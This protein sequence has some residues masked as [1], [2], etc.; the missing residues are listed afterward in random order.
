M[1]DYLE[2]KKRD[3]INDQALR[4]HNKPVLPSLEKCALASPDSPLGTGETFKRPSIK[5]CAHSSPT[6]R[7]DRL[8]P[9]IQDAGGHNFAETISQTEAHNKQET[10]QHAN[11]IVADSAVPKAAK[12]QDEES[13][14]KEEHLANFY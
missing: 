7:F 2:K 9:T 3:S 11:P 14:G 6:T 8:S 12:S 5:S 13:A 10:D 1:E 4:K